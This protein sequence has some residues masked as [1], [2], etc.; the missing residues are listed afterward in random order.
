MLN[1]MELI[2]NF[3]FGNKILELK[4]I[5]NRSDKNRQLYYI[6]GG[7]LAKELTMDGL[8]LDQFW[9]ISLLLSQF[10]NL[11]QNYHGLFINIHKQ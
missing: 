4:L 2:H 7:L 3:G 8:N 9:K 6:T 11:F 10:M 5:I 1:L